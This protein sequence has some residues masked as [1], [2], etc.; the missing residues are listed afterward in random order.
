MLHFRGHSPQCTS[1]FSSAKAG[2]EHA[3]QHDAG[4]ACILGCTTPCCRW[5]P[6]S[7][8]R[9]C[10]CPQPSP[11]RVCRPCRT[12]H[13]SRT[14]LHHGRSPLSR[15]SRTKQRAVSVSTSV[16]STVRTSPGGAERR[17]PPLFA[18][19][20]A[21]AKPA[22]A[23]AALRGCRPPRPPRCGASVIAT[24]AMSAPCCGACCLGAKRPPMARGWP[25]VQRPLPGARRF[26]PAPG[27]LLLPALPPPL[28]LLPPGS[29]P[30]AS[31]SSGGSALTRGAPVM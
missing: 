26:S 30:M 19:A 6:S 22:A 23:T 28:P 29:P 14:A 9:Q 15:I 31:G 24:A 20:A 13:P 10:L 1:L 27:L 5:Q 12:A 4:R 2:V 25:P 11:G 17:N 21:A 7:T 16:Y 3:R 8:H 18:T